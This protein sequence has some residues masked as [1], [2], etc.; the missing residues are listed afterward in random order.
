MNQVQ[1]DLVEDLAL[2][3]YLN[4]SSVLH[5]LRQRYY[6]NLIHTYAGKKTLLVVNPAR[7]LSI[8]SEKVCNYCYMVK[9][10][11]KL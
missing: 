10:K 8:Y 6:H 2:L 4:E 9:R 7:P 11:K 1:Y 5:T 3:P